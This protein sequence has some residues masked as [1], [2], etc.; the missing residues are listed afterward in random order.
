MRCMRL[1]PFTPP[2]SHA[3]WRTPGRRHGCGEIWKDVR[4]DTPPQPTVSP[5]SPERLSLALP[6]S[7]CPNAPLSCHVVPRFSNA[8]ITAHQVVRGGDQRDFLPLWIIALNALEEGTDGRRPPLQCTPNA[9]PANLPIW[10]TFTRSL[11]NFRRKHPLF[12]RKTRSSEQ[13]SVSSVVVKDASV[14]LSGQ[15]GRFSH[16]IGP[17]P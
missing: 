1:L 8:H 12:H 14:S 17:G 2:P 3:P 9:A 7:N 4:P 16:E 5:A 6:E 13:L 15:I 10:R 11:P